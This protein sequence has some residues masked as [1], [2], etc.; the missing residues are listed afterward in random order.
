MT[1][2]RMVGGMDYPEMIEEMD[3]ELNKVIQEFDR[4][5]DVEAL[6]LAKKSGAC[7]VSHSGRS[8]FT[9][10]L[11]RARVLARAAQIS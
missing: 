9:V 3:N 10:V 4:A 1:A 11:R 2:A 5:V 6:R 8:P 7:S